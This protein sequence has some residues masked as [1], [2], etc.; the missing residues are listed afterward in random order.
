MAAKAKIYQL[1]ITLTDSSPVIWRRINVP[2]N[3]T[4]ALLHDIVQVA[5]GWQ[6][7]HMYA[8]DYEEAS[9]G[10]V[11]PED[12]NGMYPADKVK[13]NELL[14]TVRDKLNYVYDMGDNWEHTLVLEKI[15]PSEGKTP[16]CTHASGACP[17]ED[18]GGISGYYNVRQVLGNP[19]D[20]DHARIK[21]ELGGKFDPNFVDTAAINK[22]LAS[23]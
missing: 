20:P 22:K 2:S 21:A 6:N 4:L 3:I 7:Q 1:K 12:D 23:L 10:E 18:C 8:F 9:F 17:P 5:M 14:K 16:V 13:L 15:L 11:F 19:Q